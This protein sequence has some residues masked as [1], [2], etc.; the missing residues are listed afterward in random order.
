ME[1]EMSRA[2]RAKRYSCKFLVE[3]LEKIKAA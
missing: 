3:K 2:M 1:V